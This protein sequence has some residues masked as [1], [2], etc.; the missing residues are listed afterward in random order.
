M[1]SEK[2][3]N[4]IDLIVSDYN[5]E[6]DI[7]IQQKELLTG[8]LKEK[9]FLKMFFNKNINFKKPLEECLPSFAL[10]KIIQQLK[11]K[12]IALGEVKDILIK[13]LQIDNV[14][15]EE[16]SQKILNNEF[17][18][19]ELEEELSTTSFKSPIKP[20]KTGLNQELI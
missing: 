8:S 13:N 18:L 14:R 12:K 2:I 11:Y 9:M 3:D 16:I 20:T 5:L 6:K 17:V 4:L 19:K 15:A 1:L 7:D 10:Y